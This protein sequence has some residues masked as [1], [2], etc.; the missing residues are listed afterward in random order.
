MARTFVMSNDME[1]R[2]EIT[3]HPDTDAYRA[4]CD[5]CA[6]WNLVN[7]RHEQWNLADTIRVAENHVERAHE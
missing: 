1:T 3:Q 2:V 6:S 7:D 5:H 4:E